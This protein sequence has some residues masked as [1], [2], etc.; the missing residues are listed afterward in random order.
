MIGISPLIG[1]GLRPSGSM[2]V[3]RVLSCTFALFAFPLLP[4]C[5]GSSSGDGNHAGSDSGGLPQTSADG[6]GQ[7]SGSMDGGGATPD[8]GGGSTSAD[9]GA[10]GGDEGGG[11]DEG[12]ATAPEGGRGGHRP[13]DAGDDAG[14]VTATPDAS[15]PDTGVVSTPTMKATMYLDNWS[16][17]FSSWAGK[18]DFT[19]MTHLLLAFAT[20]SGNSWNNLGDTNDVQTLVTAAHAKNVKVLVSIG[21]ADGTASVI[22]AYQSAS[23]I[24][25]LVAN[26]DTMVAAMNLDG[27][28]VDLETGSGMR[29]S[30]NYPAFVSQL[31]STFH[32]EGKLVTTASA[33]YIVQDQNPDAT[34]IATLKSFDFINDMIY[35]NNMGDFTSE[36]TWWTGNTIGLPKDNLVLGLCFGECGGA[37]STAFVEQITTFSEAYGGVMCWDYTDPD[38]ATL[39]PAIESAL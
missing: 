10:G 37:P 12:G 6:G 18:I 2:N 23:N 19:K 7:P 25:P 11:D 15:S 13:P 21:G 26:L 33:Q 31:I 5:G 16:G 29:S 1:A 3:R 24:A 27:V 17:S 28:D 4:A 34:I 22:S 39:W 9:T 8:A 20:P 30:S 36:A 35:S 32:A 38:E 14:H